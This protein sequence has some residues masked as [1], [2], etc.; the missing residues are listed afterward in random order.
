[1][2][3]ITT[4]YLA[5]GLML[6]L[7]LPTT[8]FAE[9]FKINGKPVPATVA[10]VNGVPLDSQL[11]ISEVK[12]YSLMNRQKNHTL[13]DQEMAEF[14]RQA[15]SR[16]VDQELI[17]QQ[18]RKKNIHVDPKNIEKRLQEVR[19]QFPSEELFHTALEMQGLTLDLLKIKFEKQSV[20]EATIR[21]EVAPHVK[22]NDPEVEDFYRKNL[23]KFQTPEK[24][25]AHH[26]FVSALQPGPHDQKFENE[27]TRKKAERLNA[28]IDQDAAEKIKDLYRQLQEGA[29]FA[30]LAQ[31]HSED[32]VT[33]KKGGG[34]GPVALSEF[35][36]VLAN[37]FRQLKQGDFSEPVRS[38]YG[39]HLLK[40]TKKIPAGHIP[41]PDIKTDI[42]NAL[43]KEKTMSE[44]Q[45]MVAEMRK[46]ADIK[47]F[48]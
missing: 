29:D 20:E 3:R 36:D 35:P 47:L 25:E 42:L 33:G 26:I 27:A 5:L 23:D 9:P 14:S 22:V 18:A 12:V 17:Y 43:L 2:K 6:F 46:K 1:M 32:N 48:Y 10:T 30:A 44:H 39:Y 41:L 7:T 31:E 28:L 45:K 8:V 4:R 13:S 38:P 16:L 40:W 15:L 37:A 11:L 34:W 19:Q 21:E 24:Y